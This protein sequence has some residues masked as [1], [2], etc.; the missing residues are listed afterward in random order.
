MIMRRARVVSHTATEK[1]WRC[2]LV[3]FSGHEFLVFVLCSD[4]G[5]REKSCCDGWDECESI[6][7]LMDVDE[8]GASSTGFI[9]IKS[10]PRSE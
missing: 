3:V 5:M 9:R 1:Q 4:G 7:M 10:G 2:V 6:L 8:N